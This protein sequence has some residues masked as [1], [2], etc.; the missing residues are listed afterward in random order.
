MIA[1]ENLLTPAFLDAVIFHIA[2]SLSAREIDPTKSSVIRELWDY[3]QLM[4]GYDF[5]DYTEALDPLVDAI[6]FTRTVQAKVEKMRGE[7]R[8][9]DEERQ[10]EVVVEALGL[11]NAA[12]ERMVAAREMADA[13]T[14]HSVRDVPA[15]G[16]S[17]TGVMG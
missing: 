8:L 16:V 9:L 6:D 5:L 12:R 11:L 10:E 4:R 7:V 13:Y 2:K 17:H 14:Y 15:G 3:R 1:K